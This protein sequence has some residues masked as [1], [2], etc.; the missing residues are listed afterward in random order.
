LR[1]E[2]VEELDTRPTGFRIEREPLDL[3][4][5]SFTVDGVRA[6]RRPLIA[7]TQPRLGRLSMHVQPNA[8]CHV[9]GDHAIVFSVL[10]LAADKTALRTTWLV[11]KDAE[12]GVDYDVDSLTT[13]WKL[14]NEQDTTFVARAHR[15]ASD[16]AYLP[17]PYMPA[18]YQVDAFCAWYVGRLAEHRAR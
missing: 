13:V 2:L 7:S 5:E 17:G 11:H 16:P 18:E 4:G 6:C 8:W 9:V 1:W 3:A 14:T 15:G 12:E 10:P